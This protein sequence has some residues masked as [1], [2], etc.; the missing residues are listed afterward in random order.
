MDTIAVLGG[1]GEVARRLVLAMVIGCA[2]GINR[3]LQN[4]PAGL[5]THA[6]VA[7]GAALIVIT[8]IGL[9]HAGTPPDTGSV[10]RVV[11]GVITGI[12]F[13][14]GG[15]ILRDSTAQSVTGLTTAASIWIAACLGIAC[16]AG[17]WQIA[18]LAVS[19]TL[20]V[21]MFGGPV[22]Q[23]IYSRLRHAGEVQHRSPGRRATDR[24]RP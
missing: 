2:L 1:F 5:R 17:Q 6:L 11:Q 20:A 16:G 21:L 10:L 14:G 19:I 13:L 8:S 12:G 18:L 3:D 7:L 9:A 22:E 15:V 23:A 24:P 4:K